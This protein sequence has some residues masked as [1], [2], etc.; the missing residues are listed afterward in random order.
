V[1]LESDPSFPDDLLH[2]LGSMTVAYSSLDTQIKLLTWKLL[3]PET[4]GVGKIVTAALSTANLLN[5][6]SSLFRYRTLDGS[7]VARMEALVG[8]ID[9]LARQ[10]NDMIHAVWISRP[11]ADSAIRGKI[12]AQRSKGLTEVAT[13]VVADD[14]Y[15]LAARLAEAR[16]ELVELEYAIV[17]SSA[18]L[19]IG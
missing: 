2:A 4:Q 9:S 8:Q 3:N 15:A 1:T 13:P 11:D 12:S 6:L 16:R 17:N 18:A 5:L 7:L 10:R 19:R 14:V